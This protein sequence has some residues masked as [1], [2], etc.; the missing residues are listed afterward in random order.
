LTDYINSGWEDSGGTDTTDD[1]KWDSE[2]AGSSDD[3]TVETSDP[4]HD[5]YHID[6]Y[7][8]GDGGDSAYMRKTVSALTTLFVRH[9][10]K[11]ITALPATGENFNILQINGSDWIAYVRLYNDSGTYKLQLGYHSGAS[12]SY[13]TWTISPTL[14]LNTWYCVEL[15]VVVH[16]STGEYRVFWNGTE[17]ITQTSLDTN[18]HGNIGAFEVGERWSTGATAH[19]IRVDCAKASDAYIG[20]EATNVF[21]TDSLTLTEAVLVNKTITITDSLG[22]SEAVGMPTATK[23]VTDTLTLSESVG[24]IADYLF[25]LTENAVRVFESDLSE[26]AERVFDTDLTADGEH[27]FGETEPILK[28]VYDA[29]TL[30]DAAPSIDKTITITDVLN[31][32]ESE[33]IRNKNISVTDSFSLTDFVI[34]NKLIQITDSLSLSDA[35]NIISRLIRITD[36]LSI[37]DTVTVLSKLIIILDTL[38]LTETPLVNK[39]I[40]IQDVVQLLETILTDKTFTVTDAINLIEYVIR[41]KTV[42]VTDTITLIEQSLLVDK[43]LQIFDSMSINDV[44]D[45]NKAIQRYLIKISSEEIPIIQISSEEID[46]IKISQEEIEP[47]KIEIEDN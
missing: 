22:L 15:K 35:V 32:I 46:T 10:F 25:S 20:L 2:Q 16:A 44:V 9:Y 7:C 21:V 14:A 30:T 36:S 40:I 27:V 37:S 6:C 29:I 43:F 12:H 26:D 11:V 34:V 18:E 45:V 38:S 39:T 24:L 17:R 13:S 31:L 8:N 5:T 41:N 4:H 28:I 3:V 23:I 33:I 1:G 47:I 42:T 19:K